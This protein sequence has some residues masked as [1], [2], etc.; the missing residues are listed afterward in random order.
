M[1]QA[2]R[3]ISIIT[4]IIDGTVR[5]LVRLSDVV[6]E[7]AKKGQGLKMAIYVY[8]KEANKATAELRR[9]T[10][11]YIHCQFPGA[12]DSLR[13]ALVTANTMRLRRL[14]Y[15]RRH[16]RRIDLRVEHLQTTATILHLAK[17]KES[18]PSM[19]PKPTT[20]NNPSGPAGPPPVLVTNATTARQTDVTTLPAQP[21]AEVPRVASPIVNHTLSFPPI[22]PD[23]ECPYCGVIIEFKGI[24]EW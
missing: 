8:D 23:N 7:S 12:P 19:P 24:A 4:Y 11:C 14:Y 15:Q 20:V 2:E 10:E 17:T 1:D 22:P 6:R 3:N 18:A 5:R 13:S 9:D 16:P 21:T